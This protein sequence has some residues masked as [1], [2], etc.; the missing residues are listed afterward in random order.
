MVR[1][2]VSA[3]SVAAVFMLLAALAVVLLPTTRLERIHPILIAWLCAP[4]L[5]GFWAMLAPKSWVPQHLPSWGAVLGL[6]AGI[7]AMVIVNVPLRVFELPLNREVRAVAVL[8]I[9][10]L[11]YIGWMIVRAVLRNLT[12][13]PSEAK[14]RHDSAH[15]A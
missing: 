3:A 15:A 7:F 9:V 1:R 4:A 12:E 5:W 10:A 8:L 13:P 14:P 2:F 6:I 11:Y